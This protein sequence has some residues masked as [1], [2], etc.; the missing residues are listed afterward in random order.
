MYDDTILRRPLKFES[1]NSYLRNL[2]RWVVHPFP[3]SFV[4]N[5]TQPKPVE[6]VKCPNRPGFFFKSVLKICSVKFFSTCEFQKNTFETFKVQRNSHMLFFGGQDGEM[7]ANI[8]TFERTVK[9]T[10][11][12]VAEEKAVI[13]YVNPPVRTLCAVDRCRVTRGQTN[14]QVKHL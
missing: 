1:I 2:K 14:V 8:L 11:G 13:P 5:V 12:I 9:P 4:L 6:W 10:V 7:S 3:V